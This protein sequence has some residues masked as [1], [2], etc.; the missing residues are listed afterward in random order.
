MQKFKNV[1]GANSNMEI[2]I[3]VEGGNMKPGPDISQKL[4]PL[5]INLGKVIS[6][7]NKATQQF[8]GMRVPVV[9]DIDTKTKDFNVKVLTPPATELIKKELSIETASS[10]PHVIKVGNLA[11]EQAINIAKSKLE[12]LPTLSL[13][14]ALKTVLGSCVSMGVLVESKDPREVIKEVEEGKYDDLIAK[15]EQEMLTV[16]PEKQAKLKRELETI[17]AQLE[18]KV[19]PAE[20]PAE[21]K[22][23]EG[24]EEKK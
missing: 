13:K 11:I 22:K 20:K 24:N 2:K 15:A 7:V 18:K 14:N 3:L 23:E 5:G 12:A 9:L 8:K 19:K 10:Q 6:E 21:E 4:G 16:S 17:K 1:Y